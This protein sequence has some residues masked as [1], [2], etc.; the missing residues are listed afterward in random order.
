MY[1]THVWTE[2]G[3]WI[4]WEIGIDIY[5]HCVCAK[6]L[7]SCPA[8][9]DTM[10]H[11]PPGSSVHGDSLGRNTGVGSHTLLQGTFPTQDLPNQEPWQAGSL[12]LTPPGKPHIY[13]YI[14]IYIYIHFHYIYTTMCKIDS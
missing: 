5:I 9:C 11:S 13:I 3:G 4:N 12:P 14:Y 2:S 1:R 6:S 10:D 8:L 7:Q